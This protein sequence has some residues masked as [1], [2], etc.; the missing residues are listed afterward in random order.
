MSSHI[1][2]RDSSLD[3][4]KG[5]GILCI[6]LLHFESGIFP[7]W[8][9]LW[10]GLFMVNTFYFTSG[11][12]MS[13]K[14]T[15]PTP[16]EL[17]RRRLRQLGLPYLWFS[18][19][20]LAF[21]LLWWMLGQM[22]LKIFFRD[23]YKALCLHGIGTLWF[24]PALLG[25]ELLF[26]LLAHRKRP[27]LVGLL[28]FALS[29]LGCWLYHHSWLPLRDLDDLHRILD[30]PM[31]V[32]IRCFQGWP[33]VVL[34]YFVG[35]FLAPRLPRLSRCALIPLGALLLGISLLL[36]WPKLP[37]LGYPGQWL[38]NTLPEMGLLCLF[39]AL[40]KGPLLNFFA[41]W[42]KNSLILM[43]THFSILEEIFKSFDRV[44]LGHPEFTGGIT[45]LYFL[46]TLLLTYP[47]VWLF[48]HKFPFFL[49]KAHLSRPT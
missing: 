20:I 19:L 33:I 46:L 8:L 7:D 29:A 10:I 23:L 25:S 38:S 32:F 18:L 9:N 37:P 17:L 49:G 11:W 28:L 2:H 41:Y 48:H 40:P 24:L 14:T 22:P 21:N 44:V 15:L 36:M 3:A 34:G 1:S 43:C 42:G 4:I 39:L 13:L 47:L 26:C 45:L 5:V 6:T 12:L 30:A 31:H 27:L 35:R 16:K